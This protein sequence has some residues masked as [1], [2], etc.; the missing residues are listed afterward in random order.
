MRLWIILNNLFP[1]IPRYHIT[2]TAGTQTKSVYPTKAVDQYRNRFKIT[3]VNGTIIESIVDLDLLGW[4]LNSSIWLTKADGKLTES[5]LSHKADG[6]L[7]E[8]CMRH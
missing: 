6:T 2:Q 5:S 4:W 3:K 8:V 7:T 1:A